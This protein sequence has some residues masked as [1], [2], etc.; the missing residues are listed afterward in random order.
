MKK[1]IQLLFHAKLKNK[2]H[3][4]ICTDLNETSLDMD[5]HYFYHR[6]DEF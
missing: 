4:G 3:I 2:R 5:K 6:V 1:K